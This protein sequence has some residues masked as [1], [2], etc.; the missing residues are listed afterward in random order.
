ML[1]GVE[2]RH[3]CL[4]EHFERSRLLYA[5]YMPRI[6]QK[7]KNG[8]FY[9]SKS[10]LRKARE[11]DPV[12]SLFNISNEATPLLWLYSINILNI[13]S[14]GQ[15]SGQSKI[16][17]RLWICMLCLLLLTMYNTSF[18]R[19]PTSAPPSTRHNYSG[20]AL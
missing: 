13:R 10:I 9:T 1:Q 19:L 16:R 15:Q 6:G 12:F 2:C 18:Y 11:K 14:S 3:V 4:F 7:S 17:L 20:K 5:L 8:S